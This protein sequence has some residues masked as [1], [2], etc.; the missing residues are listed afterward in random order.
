MR[1]LYWWTSSVR[2]TAP[3]LSDNALNLVDY[4]AGLLHE[5]I[6]QIVERFQTV[7][8]APAA[9]G[10]NPTLTLSPRTS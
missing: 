10:Y 2:I 7:T 5:P 8:G 4:R 3:T 1:E 9:P 6:D